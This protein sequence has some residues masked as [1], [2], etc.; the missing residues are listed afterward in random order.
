[1]L[2]PLKN[3]KTRIEE[4]GGRRLFLALVGGV[5]AAAPATVPLNAVAQTEPENDR[6]PGF[7]LELDGGAEYDSVVSLDELDLSSVDGDTA[8]LIDATAGYSQQL[9]ETVE[10][11]LSYSYSI[12]DYQDID[13]VDQDSHIL[14][15]DIS[16]DLGNADIG[17][18]GFYVNSE[19]NDEDF[20][21]LGRISPYVSGFFADGWFARGAVVYSDKTNDV[22]PGRD[23]SAAIA[24]ID[25]YHFPAGKPWYL[26]VG[27][28][29]RDEDATA[30][31][32][33]YI[34]NTF[35]ARAVY[36]LSLWEK[37]ARFEL[38]FRRLDRDYSSITPSIGQERFDQRDRTNVEFQLSL[39]SSLDARIY[40]TYSDWESNL[41][42]VNFHQHVAGLRLNY[43]W[44]N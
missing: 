44:E 40:Y 6:K 8:F 36:R 25:L 27:Y 22:N 5:I 43:R 29:Y 30:A 32:F 42:S 41:P 12:I 20:L 37:S 34:G 13:E 35:K 19:L 38:S 28:K 4:R 9:G 33:D 11:D 15:G 18:T 31:R 24:E 26:N 21:E 2:A 7:S 23:A 39:T 14:S 17:L 3:G 1:M 16:K 10:L